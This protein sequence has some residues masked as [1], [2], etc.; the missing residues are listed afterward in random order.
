ML[1]LFPETTPTEQEVRSLEGQTVVFCYDYQIEEN[2]VWVY[3]RLPRELGAHVVKME[4]LEVPISLHV[5]VNYAL[6]E[7]W[8]VMVKYMEP[9]FVIH[10]G[11]HKRTLKDLF[12]AKRTKPVFSRCFKGFSKPNK[13][14]P[15]HIEFGFDS[16]EAYDRFRTTLAQV[17][18]AYFDF[19]EKGKSNRNLL[20]LFKLAAAKSLKNPIFRMSEDDTSRNYLCKLQRQFGFVLAGWNSVRLRD[21]SFAKGQ[22]V[23]GCAVSEISAAPAVQT[24]APLSVLAWDI[25]VATKS[26]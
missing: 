17:N 4:L 23:A 12:V 21:L 11:E 8:C 25:E 18:T 15:S 24:E 26:G 9:V 19:V 7:D 5:Q 16:F 20:A 1:D 14:L 3:G 10:R 22:L 13:V 2:C 6:F